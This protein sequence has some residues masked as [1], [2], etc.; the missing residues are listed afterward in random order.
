MKLTLLFAYLL[1][2]QIAVCQNQEKYSEYVQEAWQLYEADNYKQSAA[3]YKEAFDQMQGKASPN[4]RYNAACSYALSDQA[5]SSFYHLFYLAENPRIQYKNLAHITT[6]PDLNSLHSLDRWSA[7][8]DIVK[9][10]K[11]EYEK[12]LDMPL[13][14]QLDSIYQLDQSYR[15]QLGEIEEKYGRESDEMKAH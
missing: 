13:V 5:D 4:D 2:V 7:L 1:T 3:T 12:N 14:T 6:D 9:A 10:N 11:T 15:K 8:I